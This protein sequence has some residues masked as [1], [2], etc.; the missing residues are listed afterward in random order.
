[1]VNQ[2]LTKGLA[3]GTTSGMTAGALYALITPDVGLAHGTFVG[4]VAGAVAGVVWQ[5][6]WE[7]D[8]I[9]RR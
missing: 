1:M 5:L 7:R 8:G 6:G 9:K 3:V 4:L 2:S